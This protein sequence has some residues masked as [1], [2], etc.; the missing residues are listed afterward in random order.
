MKKVIRGK[1]LTIK[2]LREKDLPYL[3]R[4]WNDGRV[5]APVD[6]PNGLGVTMEDMHQK[7][8]PRW[9]DDPMEFMKIIHLKN[10][11]PIGEANFRNY[12][13]EEKTV[14]IGLKICLPELWG[15]GLGTEALKLMT[16]YAFEVLRADRVLVNP[17]RTNLRI[18]HVNEKVGF[19][20][21]GEK[22]G[23]LLMELKRK[24]WLRD[25]SYP[26]LDGRGP[27]GG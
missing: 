3:A 25:H 11:T 16:D 22:D 20:T 18:I 17:S 24:D 4:W 10:N 9:R 21:V 14:E 5:M 15:Q 8:W 19:R 1:R 6:A 7:Y 2:P 26:S 12:N 27:G 13:I 23:G